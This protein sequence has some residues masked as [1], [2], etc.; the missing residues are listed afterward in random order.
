MDI[1]LTSPATAPVARPSLYDPAVGATAPKKD[2]DKETFLNLLVAQLRNQDPSSPMD[3]NAMMAQSSQL[4]SM[5]QLTGLADT[6]R[7]QFGLQMRMAASTFIG[8]EVAF[9]DA[10]GVKRTG[11]VTGAAFDGAVPTMTV[12][13]YKV[14]LDSISAVTAASSAAPNAATSPATTATTA[15]TAATPT[16]SPDPDG[17][18]SSTPPSA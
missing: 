7:D 5:E 9:V 1:P 13:G 8:K 12:G 17:T 4:A 14:P 16:T 18:T 2:L 11:T 15:T 6:S 3:T 10:A